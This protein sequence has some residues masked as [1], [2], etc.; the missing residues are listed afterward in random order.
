MKNRLT[1][2]SPGNLAHDPLLDDQDG[3]P[4]PCGR[5]A[6]GR[7]SAYIPRRPTCRKVP[8]EF[9]FLAGNS[10]TRVRGAYALRSWQSTKEKCRLV[11]GAKGRVSRAAHSY[12]K[13]VMGSTRVARRAGTQ[14]AIKPISKSRTATPPNVIGS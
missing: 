3:W 10:E 7:S 1:I 4:G 12:R 14:Q 2:E 5:Y 13:A 8:R 6:T 9:K 11:L